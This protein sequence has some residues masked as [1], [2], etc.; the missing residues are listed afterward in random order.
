MGSLLVVIP[1][2]GT[3][4]VA[5]TVFRSGIQLAELTKSQSPSEILETSFAH[6]ASFARRNGTG[7]PVVVDSDT[8]NWLAAV[9]TWFHESGFASGQERRLLTR[10]NEVGPDQ[11][12]K[13]LDGFFVVAIGNAVTREVTLATDVFGTLH[14]YFRSLDGVMAISTSSLILAGLDDI[15]L[16]SIAC[17][18]FLQ[19]GA[20]YEDRTF[21]KEVRKLE[22]AQCFRYKDGVLKGR[23][24]YWRVTDLTPDSLDGSDSV[25]ALR[26]SALAAARLI[27]SV[28]PQPV[29]D[30]TGGYDSRVG[31]AA[32]ATAGLKF[33]TAVS[34]ESAHPDVEISRELSSRMGVEL[35]YSNPG[36]VS[37]FA[38][39]QNALQ[40][41]DGE[42]DLV[43]YARI[44]EVQAALATEFDISV[45]S[46]SGEIGRGYGWEVL[47][48][49][50]GKRIPL[51]S[52]TAAKRRFACSIYEEAIFP[53]D[54][55]IDPSIHFKGVIDRINDGLE[56]LPNTLQYDYCMSMLRCQ[57]WYGRIASSTNQIYPCM[58]F[59]L[60][61][62]MIEPMLETNTRS[63]RNSLLMRRLLAD[64]QP[65]LAEYPLD[66]GYPPLP[67]TWK[68]LHRFW[69]LIPL[70]GGKVINKIRGRL[71]SGHTDSVESGGGP[72]LALWQDP[73]V[74]N[75]LHRDNLQTT[76]IF[77]AKE[78]ER[79][80]K[81]S[82]LKNF[83]YP[84]QWSFL[85][86]L[87]CALQSLKS[88][89]EQVRE[90]R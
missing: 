44:Y 11:L 21:Y 62:S 71:L 40:L 30:L 43:D 78:L 49:H 5:R 24:H 73:G 70:Y 26:E 55:R 60:F 88:I 74:Q 80:I 36:T 4:Q 83:Q 46:Y 50:T 13:E 52:A 6:V 64:I 81:A 86:S 79:F 56:N 20:M 1:G 57:R 38:Q 33:C 14:C 89:R 42:Y 75:A 61:R 31:V 82:K 69:P 25:D 59:F 15:S 27:S 37:K 84:E 41:T 23:Q 29:V 34:G 65:M 35:R 51:A 18:E 90:S 54:T 85:L 77:D 16:D 17:Q 3:E 53:P 45:N 58:S 28:F 10:L 67:V 87:E 22:A 76:Q 12:V 32:F 8:G 63:R 2:P 48:P 68:T 19:T 72:R 39:L 66:L 47:I 7:T 9:G